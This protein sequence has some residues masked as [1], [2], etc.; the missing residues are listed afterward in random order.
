MLSSSIQRTIRLPGDQI[1]LDKNVS[2]EGTGIGVSLYKLNESTYIVTT[3]SL[4]DIEENEKK[5][6]RIIP[7]KG[8]YMPKEGDIVIGIVYDVTLSSWLIDIKSPYLATL[9]ASDYIGKPFNPAT[10]NIRKYLDVGDVIIAKVAQFDRTRQ[11]VLT[12]QDKGL[13]KVINGSLVEIEPSKIG[14]VIGKK[15]SMLSMLM[16]QTKCDFVVGVNGRVLLRCPDAELEYIAILALKKIEVEAHTAGLT[17]RIK[18]FI[19]NE[20]VKRGLIKYES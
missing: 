19:I 5:K 4:Q 18:E 8:R 14:R 6:I 2:V 12:V 3:I 7:L 15:R 10:D 9:N 20:K 16:E 11:P 13:G 1:V 17:E